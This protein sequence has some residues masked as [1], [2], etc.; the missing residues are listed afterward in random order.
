MDRI[1]KSMMD[2]F[3]ND[4][5]IEVT[6]ESDIFEMFC[7]YCILSRERSDSEQLD[8]NDIYEVTTAG[9]D[10][11]GLDGIII[12]VDGKLLN[13]KEEVD[14]LK[15]R[16]SVRVSLIF[17]QSKTSDSFIKEDIGYFSDGAWSFFA[18]F[19]QGKQKSLFEE[20][21]KKLGGNQKILEKSELATQLLTSC[22]SKLEPKP[23]CKL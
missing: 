10:D 4:Y 2:E 5:N 1:T 18:D 8:I 17:V 19:L 23:T 11:R 15:K 16:A 12:L 7:N 20:P 13:S 3:M 21:N 14:E 6:Q 9:R 22:I